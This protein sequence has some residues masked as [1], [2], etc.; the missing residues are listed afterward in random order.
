MDIADKAQ[1]AY[2][3]LESRLIQYAISNRKK[4]VPFRGYCHYCYESVNSP[5]AFCDAD[6]QEDWDKEQRI[7]T[8]NGIK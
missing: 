2:E 5:S 7:R 6:C 8:I 3:F 1:E 4:A